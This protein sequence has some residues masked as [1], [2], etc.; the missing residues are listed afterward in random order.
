MSLQALDAQ[1][2]GRWDEAEAL[3]AAAVEQCPSDDRARQG[4]AEALWRRGLQTE[5]VTH[6]EEA[7]RLSGS[8][9]ERL[10][11]LGG[12]YL[13][14]GQT[15]R[16]AEQ[17]LQAIAANPQHAGAWALRG[18]VQQVEGMRDEALA[19]YFRALSFQP[20]QPAVQLAIAEIYAQQNR[21]QRALA[22]L[23]A[24]AA[25]YPPARVPPEVRHRE[26]LALRELGRH[27]DANAALSQATNQGNSTAEPREGVVAAVSGERPDPR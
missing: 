22:T 11:Q 4:Y 16:A 12:M 20:H 2:Q 18:Q 9:P 7:V 1:Q 13:A 8:D 14:Q 27:A 10:V 6:M 21:P 25:D 24:L 3:F 5:A 17:A 23:Q 19:S 15:H 26:G